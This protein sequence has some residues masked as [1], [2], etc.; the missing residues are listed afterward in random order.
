MALPSFAA[1]PRDDACWGEGVSF[2]RGDGQT[3]HLILA[4][5]APETQAQSSPIVPVGESSGAG[6]F[7]VY[8]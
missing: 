7:P 8:W 3:K 5:Y 2:G 6:P 4:Y 1:G